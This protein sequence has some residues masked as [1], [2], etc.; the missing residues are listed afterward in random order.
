MIC[1]MAAPNV[2]ANNVTANNVIVAER[3]SVRLLILQCVF[4]WRGVVSRFRNAICHAQKCK[5]SR[6]GMQLKVWRV[7]KHPSRLGMQ[8]KHPVYKSCIHLRKFI[9]LSA[10]AALV[11]SL[12]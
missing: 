5:M 8:L 7:R 11:V 10:V 6:S 9:A 1:E 2:T 3:H 4:G 12:S